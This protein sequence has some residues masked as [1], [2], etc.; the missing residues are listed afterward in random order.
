MDIRDTYQFIVLAV[1]LA[2]SAF[3]SSIETALMSVNRIRL[4]TL[5]D[6]G[7]KRAALALDI[8][9]NKTPKML[10]AILIGNNI[11]NVY[12]SC[13]Q[14]HLHITWEATWSALRRWL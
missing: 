7:N 4:R 10:S 3:F 6:D 9:E 12:A 2:L 5:S 14:L 13:L 8:L 1:L 11:V